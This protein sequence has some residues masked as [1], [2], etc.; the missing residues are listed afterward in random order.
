MI[1]TDAESG[2]DLHAGRQR[3]D[4]GGIEAIPGSAQD[5]RG[6]G[7]PGAADDLGP[8]SRPGRVLRVQA[9]IVI[10]GSARLDRLGQLA[11]DE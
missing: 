6:A 8:E 5:A 2:D 11:G 7:L 4:A 3:I 1:V 10:A 9:G